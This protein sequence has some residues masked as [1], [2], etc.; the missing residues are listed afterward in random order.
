[1]AKI[2]N[3]ALNFAVN[4]AIAFGI[5]SYLRDRKTGVKAGLVLGTI[6]AIA[7]MVMGGDG[8]DLAEEFDVTEEV[9]SES[10]AAATSD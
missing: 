6:A 5:A 10:E 4:F 9:E 3:A 2:K 1:M 7:A 8:E